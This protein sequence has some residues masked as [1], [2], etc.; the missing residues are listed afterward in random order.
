MKGEKIRPV[1]YSVKGGPPTY[2]PPAEPDLRKVADDLYRKHK[3]RKRIE[4]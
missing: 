3:E 2:T 1:D 4:I